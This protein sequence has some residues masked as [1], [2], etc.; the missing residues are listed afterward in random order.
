MLKIYY[1]YYAV[2]VDNEPYKRLRINGYTMRDDSLPTEELIINNA[3]FEKIY[4]MESEDLPFGINCYETTFLKK[5]IVEVYYNCAATKYKHF[6]TLS[7]KR[8]YEEMNYLS[9]AEIFKRFPAEK[10]I[11][12]LKEHGLNTCPIIKE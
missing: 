6:D 5:P 4:S 12:Y 10:C 2:S 9:L 7:Y 8:V 11:Q 1:S 3:P